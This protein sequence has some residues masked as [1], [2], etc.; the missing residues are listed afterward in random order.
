MKF[1]KDFVTNSSS[2]SFVCE[3]CGTSEVYYDGL[4]EVG[5]CQC[6]NGHEFCQEHLLDMSREEMIQIILKTEY[7]YS[8][9]GGFFH[10]TQEELSDKNDDELYGLLTDNMRE[11]PSEFCPICQFIEYSEND[12]ATYLEKEYKVS[13]DEAFAEVKKANKR[14]KKLYDSEYITYVATKFGLN[15][16]EIQ[17]SWKEKFKSYEEFRDFLRGDN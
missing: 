11:V 6:E 2:S 1:R 7:Y 12:M 13:R 9:R 8:E 3:I 14:R 15:I 10:Y 4:S 16:P 17:A 5:A